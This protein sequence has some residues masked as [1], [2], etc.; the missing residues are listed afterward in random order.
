M[1]LIL[2]R[3]LAVAYQRFMSFVSSVLCVIK[4]FPSVGWH[5]S[6]AA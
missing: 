1:I 5:Q 3:A 6:G 2:C 4:S